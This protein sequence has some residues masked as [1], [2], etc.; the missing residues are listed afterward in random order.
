MLPEDFVRKVLVGRLNVKYLFCGEDFRFGKDRAGTTEILKDYGVKYGFSLTVFSK[1]TSR[2]EI[3]SSTL[4]REALDAGDMKKF[5][6]ASGN[7]YTI[8]GVVVHGIHLATQFGYPT[9]NIVPQPEKLLP[10]FG[11]YYVRVTIDGEVYDGMANLGV[12]PTITTENLP[13]LETNLLDTDRDLYDKMTVTEFI[14]FI[15]PEK[16]FA[17]VE[18]LEEQIR[19]DLKTVRRYAQHRSDSERIINSK[20]D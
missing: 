8:S 7:P 1:C 20:N 16:K 5:M 11:V 13:L 15:R 12:K 2:G 10:R 9:I 19:A 6:A 3:V 14:R 18:D 4:L 17:S